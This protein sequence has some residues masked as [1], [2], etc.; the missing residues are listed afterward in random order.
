MSTPVTPRKNVRAFGGSGGSGAAKPGEWFDSK[1]PNCIDFD[2]A[3]KYFIHHLM[4]CSLMLEQFPYMMHQTHPSF[5]NEKISSTCPTSLCIAT[6]ARFL[7]F[8]STLLY[9]YFSPC[10]LMLKKPATALL[11][12]PKLHPPSKMYCL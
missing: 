12:V 9:L 6:R 5:S 10:L 2:K 7:T 8:L 3:G 11:A 4:A 1:I